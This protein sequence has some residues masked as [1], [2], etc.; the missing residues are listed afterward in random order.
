M[1]ELGDALKVCLAE[2]VMI[3]PKDPIEYIGKYL[4]NYKKHQE[5]L[6]REAEEERIIQEAIKKREE[7]AEQLLRLKEEKRLEEEKKAMLLQ[8]EK[9]KN[10]AEETLDESHDD[11]P[12][13]GEGEGS[14]HEEV[15]EIKDENEPPEIKVD[16]EPDREEE[17]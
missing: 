3:K 6:I 16:A 17:A 8:Q 10:V 2:V 11:R 15:S 5:F 12:E 4:I 7:E 13:V 14:T 9:Q 1:K